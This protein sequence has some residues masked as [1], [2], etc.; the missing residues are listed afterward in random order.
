MHFS[1]SFQG[2]VSRDDWIKTA[3]RYC[4]RTVFSKSYT[5]EV[6]T[7]TRFV[8]ILRYAKQKRYNVRYDADNI[9]FI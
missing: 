1:G 2:N 7:V 6:T 3:I 4:K 9:F 5:I 8:S